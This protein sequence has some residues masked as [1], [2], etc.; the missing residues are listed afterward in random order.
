M[1]FSLIKSVIIQKKKKKENILTCVHFFDKM[2]VNFFLNNFS[3][4]IRLGISSESLFTQN[5]KTYFP[6]KYIYKK[7]SAAVVVT[8]L[9]V[10]YFNWFY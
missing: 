1:S 8:I 9:R 2:L 5:A 4:E 3:E 7:F 10:K 6:E